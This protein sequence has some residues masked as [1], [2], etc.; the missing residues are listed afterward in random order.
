MLYNDNTTGK[1]L[2]ILAN[3]NFD[4]PNSVKFDE[5]VNNTMDGNG[6]QAKFIYRSGVNSSFTGIISEQWILEPGEIV[7]GYIE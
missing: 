3:R 4:A 1:N 2:F 5:I 6:K 7:I